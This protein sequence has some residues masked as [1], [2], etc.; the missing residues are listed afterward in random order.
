MKLIKIDSDDYAV[1]DDSQIVE[2]DTI[3]TFALGL[4]GHGRGWYISTYTGDKVSK[5]NVLAGGKK[6]THS[7]KL[8][9]VYPLKLS[10]IL[11][12]IGVV[13]V[14]KLASEYTNKRNYLFEEERGF[15]DGYN[16]ALEDNK[17]KLYTEKH[18]KEAFYF[19]RN[20]LTTN[21]DAYIINKITWDVEFVD[22]QLKLKYE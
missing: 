8:S 13:N 10:D 1:I 5:L 15:L 11:E 2:G 12:L 14:E 3:A 20:K 19:G 9:E 22:G 17:D 21:F 7:T 16:K 18:L 6:V 4:N